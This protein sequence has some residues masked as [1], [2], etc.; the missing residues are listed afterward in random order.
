MKKHFLK[1]FYLLLIHS[2]ILPSQNQ[3][4]VLTP[5]GFKNTNNL[6]INYLIIDNPELTKQELYNFTLENIK[7]THPSINWIKPIKK[8]IIIIKGF[9]S[10]KI[11][12]NFIH[13]FDIDYTVSFQFM[14]GKIKIEAPLFELNGGSTHPQK[15]HLVYTK[16]SF[17][18]S[19]L[20]IYG[21]KNKLK[22]KKAKSDLENYFNDFISLY[23]NNLNQKLTP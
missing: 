3:K 17:D 21:K 22:S 4:F 6:S 8:E 5:E 13:F 15:L 14:D 23:I 7:N 9:D 10:E 11:K 12:R 20:G 1:L 16:F 2:S 18:G 19:D